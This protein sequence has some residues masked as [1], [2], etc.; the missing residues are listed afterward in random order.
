MAVIRSRAA[1]SL[2]HESLAAARVSEVLGIAPSESFEIGDPFARGADLVRACR[3]G[4]EHGLELAESHALAPAESELFGCVYIDP[5]ERAGADADIS[6]WVVDDAQGGPL[7]Q[8][9]AEIVPRWVSEAWPFVQP[10]F[11]GRDLSWT[12]WLALPERAEAAD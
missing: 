9:L 4:H 1:L 10:R 6:W 12:E 5:P 7:E 8:A 11:I 2:Q 3:T